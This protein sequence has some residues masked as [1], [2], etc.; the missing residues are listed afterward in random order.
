MTETSAWHSPRAEVHHDNKS[1]ATSRRI[2]SRDLRTGT[3]GRPLC[4]NCKRLDNELGSN[5]FVPA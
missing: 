5:G 3:G 1:C 2:K 4:P